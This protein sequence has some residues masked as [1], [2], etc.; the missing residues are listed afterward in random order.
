MNLRDGVDTTEA[1]EA[2]S[3]VSIGLDFQESQ[4]WQGMKCGKWN[5]TQGMSIN[6]MTHIAI[7]SIQI[8]TGMQLVLDAYSHM[9]G[10]GWYR[11]LLLL[12]CRG[13]QV[14]MAAFGNS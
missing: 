4:L 8:S 13:E 2:F 1:S 6:T 14:K 3:C 10:P 11:H 9:I 12:E 5:L 7:A